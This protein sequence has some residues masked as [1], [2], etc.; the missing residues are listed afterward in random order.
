MLVF[1]A[2]VRHAV[3]IIFGVIQVKRWQSYSASEMLKLFFF[4]KL[5]KTFKPFGSLFL[6]LAFETF[7]SQLSIFVAASYSFHKE[8]K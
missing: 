4:T 1:N 8:P 5:L 3:N 2:H 6:N 7:D